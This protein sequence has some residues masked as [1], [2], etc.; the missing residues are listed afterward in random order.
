MTL[1]GKRDAGRPRPNVP[2]LSQATCADLSIPAD[3]LINRI[4]YGLSTCL[5]LGDAFPFFN[6][7]CFGPGILAAFL[8]SI[9]DNSTG[10]FWFHPPSRKPIQEIHFQ[11]DPD[12][13]WFRRIREIYEAAMRRWQGA[14]V[15]GMT[16]LGGNLDILSTFRPS[17]E[18]LLDLYDNPGEVIRLLWEE[19][20]V[21][22]QYY[23]ALNDILQPVNPGYCDW[24]GIYSDKA[25]YVLQCDFS[26]MI[27][28]AMFDEFVKPEL[29]ATCARLERCIYHLDGTGALAHLDSLLAIPDLDVVQWVPG[30]GQADCG[31]WPEVYKKIAA[32]GKKIQVHG[33][34]RE[35]EAL[36]SVIEQVG[37]SKGIHLRGWWQD[38]ETDIRRELSKHG[39][40]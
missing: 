10:R 6:M 38:S 25:S 9:P 14:V 3:D 2:L 28:P 39:V 20:E 5:Y 17:E 7:D 30:D 22:H 37:T 11:F 18:L 32:A 19:H 26:Y 1:R 35:F 8:G 34:V 15:M 4:D 36:D 27:G 16:D 21:W 31:H 24:S 23:N 12:N 29:V 33:E 40:E 13:V